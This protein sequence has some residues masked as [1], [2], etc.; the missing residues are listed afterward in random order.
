MP[1]VYIL[2]LNYRNWQDTLEC[3]ESVFRLEYPNFHVIVIDNDSGNGSLERLMEHA[4]ASRWPETSRL[5]AGTPDY[6]YFHSRDLGV[7]VHADSLSR[8]VFIQNEKNTGFAGG[9]NIALKLLTGEDAYVWLLNPDM[10]V[11]EDTLTQLVNFAT[12]QP[13]RSIIGAVIKYHEQPA[14]IHFYGGC[15]IRFYSATIMPV[16]APD[17]VSRLDYIS[18][19]SLFTKAAGFREIGLLPEEYFLY[20]EETDWCYR[21]RQAGFQLAVCPT[22]VCFDKVGTSIGRGF[23]AEYYYTRNGL[24]FVSRYQPG[25]I[26]FV[27][28]F[29]LFRL[30][31]RTLSG[32]WDRARGIREG[33]LAYLKRDSNEAK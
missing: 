19:G 18:G 33:I 14:K 20:W 2:I 10:V 23:A 17:Q 9:N 26:P 29:S 6:Q 1:R 22:A 21:A 8:L 15:R 24:L 32:R 28:F 27:V 30:L 13:A 4:K 7:T 12:G 31:K 25:K 16:T 3:L 5:T 11:Q